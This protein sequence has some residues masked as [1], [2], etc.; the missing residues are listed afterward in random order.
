MDA[1]KEKE[2]NTK[3]V[4]CA[5]LFLCIDMSVWPSWS[6][7]RDSSSRGASRTGSNPVALITITAACMSSDRMNNEKYNFVYDNRQ[8]RHVLN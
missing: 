1:D 5:L 4:K 2:Y 3:C 7:A 8:D 6:K